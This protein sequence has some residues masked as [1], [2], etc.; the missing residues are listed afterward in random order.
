[1]DVFIKIFSKFGMMISSFAGVLAAF[2]WFTSASFQRTATALTPET[3]EQTEQLQ[4]ILL[5]VSDMNYYASVF[6][7]VAAFF[8]LFAWLDS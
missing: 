1:M 5:T 6:S 4:S 3:V 2:C 7:G 8:A